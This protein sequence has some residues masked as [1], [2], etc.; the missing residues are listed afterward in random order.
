MEKKF[1]AWLGQFSERFKA[2]EPALTRKKKQGC[3][4]GSQ[5]IH[6]SRIVEF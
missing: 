1:L 2:G 3:F 6:D 5:P 4:K